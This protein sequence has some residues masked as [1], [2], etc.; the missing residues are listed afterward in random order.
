MA[1]QF[2][3][4][5]T[6]RWTGRGIIAR[7]VIPEGFRV[8]VPVVVAVTQDEEFV[9]AVNRFIRIKRSDGTIEALYDHWILGKAVASSGRRWSVLKDVLGWSEQ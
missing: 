9:E 6:C 8:R 7:L 4:L 5:S 3:A 2:A 1:P